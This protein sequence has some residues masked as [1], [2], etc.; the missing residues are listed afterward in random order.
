MP[1]PEIPLLD[2]RYS[3]F[4]KFAADK[5][6]T[7]VNLLHVLTRRHIAPY[8]GETSTPSFTVMYVRTAYQ[9]SPSWEISDGML[10]V[11]NTT[12]WEHLSR[13]CTQYAKPCL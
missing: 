7:E 11:L 10:N 4:R 9:F 12:S 1:L 6:D 2:L 3:V 8:F 5:L 13:F